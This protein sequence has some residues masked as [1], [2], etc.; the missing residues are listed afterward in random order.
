LVKIVQY[1]YDI[2][3]WSLSYNQT[4]V[5]LFFINSDMSCKCVTCKVGITDK[6]THEIN[7]PVKSLYENVTEYVSTLPIFTSEVWTFLVRLI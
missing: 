1:L 2:H 3:E 4:L 6:E 7:E 5:K